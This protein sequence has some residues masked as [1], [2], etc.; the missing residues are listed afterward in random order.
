MTQRHYRRK[1]G[2]N[3]IDDLVFNEMNQLGDVVSDEMLALIKQYGINGETRLQ[4]WSR[5]DAFST[6]ANAI[7][8]AQRQLVSQLIDLWNELHAESKTNRAIE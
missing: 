8:N 5:S 7:Q 1:P 2:D 6:Q 4:E 3:F